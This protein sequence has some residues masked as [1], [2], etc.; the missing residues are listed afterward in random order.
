MKMIGGGGGGGGGGG[1]NRWVRV[2]EG[3]NPLNVH[4]WVLKLGL[5]NMEKLLYCA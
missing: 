3:V 4:K 1:L 2:G 5:K